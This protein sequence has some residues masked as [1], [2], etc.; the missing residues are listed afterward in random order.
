MPSGNGR[1]LRCRRRRDRRRS[2]VHRTVKLYHSSPAT[3]TKKG[4]PI[5][6]A[7]FGAVDGTRTRTVS[8]PGDFK[9]PVSTDSTTTAAKPRKVE[10][11]QPLSR[12]FVIFLLCCPCLAPARLRPPHQKSQQ[13]LLP[14]GAS[15]FSRKRARENLSGFDFPRLSGMI[16]QIFPIVKTKG[17]ICRRK[18]SL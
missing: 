14:R 1:Q 7:L 3:N 16:S 15:Q 5:G 4:T 2:T 11:R 6:G 12:Y 9:S 13:N 18:E 8:L 17:V 10:R